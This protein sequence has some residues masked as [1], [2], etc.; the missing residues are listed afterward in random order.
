[1]AEQSKRI[2]LVTGCSAGGIGDALAL[3]FA[4]LGYRVLATVRNPAKAVHLEGVTGIELLTL[5]VSSAES[6]Q[7]LGATLRQ[8]LHPHGRLDV[9]VNNAGR[10]AT[11]PLLDVDLAEAK[12]L[13]D[14][15]IWG[16]LAV[17]QA[18]APFLIAAGG[19][20]ANISSVGG[21]LALPWSGMLLAC[22]AK[23]LTKLNTFCRAISF[24]QSCRDHFER[25]HAP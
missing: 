10:G 24:V 17:T 18:C 6:T 1:M 2:A 13:W 3:R 22:R 21:L 16:M 8:R 19:V 7:A 11:S 14:T 20:I 9:L 12:S 15:N 25:D 4:A 23:A 5:D